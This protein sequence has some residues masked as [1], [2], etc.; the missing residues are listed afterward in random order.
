MAF[1]KIKHQSG[2]SKSRYYLFMII[3]MIGLVG[4]FNAMRFVT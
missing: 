2:L 3:S 4:Y 1:L